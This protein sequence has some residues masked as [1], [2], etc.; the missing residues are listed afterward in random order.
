MYAQSRYHQDQPPKVRIHFDGTS[1]AIEDYLA[2]HI[3]SEQRRDDG[4]VRCLM[5]ANHLNNPVPYDLETVRAL[6]QYKSIVDMFLQN[7]APTDEYKQVMNEIELL[8]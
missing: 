1:E 7:K 6:P 4:R 2:H 8:G 3:P 5:V